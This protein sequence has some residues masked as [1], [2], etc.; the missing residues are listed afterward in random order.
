LIDARKMP[1]QARPMDFPD[2]CRHFLASDH[3]M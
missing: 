3:F 1:P 2:S